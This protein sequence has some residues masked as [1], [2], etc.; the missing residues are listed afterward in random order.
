[1]PV[2]KQIPPRTGY[3]RIPNDVLQSPYL[4]Q[5]EKAVLGYGL[6][7]EDN[8]KFKRCEIQKSVGISPG[9]VDRAIE[10]LEK[11]GYVDGDFC[12][13]GQSDLTFHAY[14]IGRIEKKSVCESKRTSFTK[15][16]YI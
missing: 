5:F 7:M 16:D 3:G 1:M 15:N 10:G 11:K 12:R 8:H 4:N 9:A 2:D 6:S 13:S 14:P